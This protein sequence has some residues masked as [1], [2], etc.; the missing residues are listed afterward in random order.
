MT[1][2]EIRPF[3]A[4]DRDWLVDAHSRLYAAEEG[5]D[6]SFGPLVAD[7][8]DKFIADHD[9]QDE[10][11]WIA[12]EGENR[13]GSIFCVRLD[14]KRAK[15]RLF[16]LQPEARGKGL[17]L[18]LLN[19]CMDFARARGYSGMQLWT[20]E[21]HRAACALYQRNGW[22][23]TAQ[24]PVHAFGQDLIEQTYEITF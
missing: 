10:A 8:L 23:V 14:E 21:S 17:G 24:K 13:L 1:T 3:T 5:F 9:S 15:L 12:W 2:I 22:R 6:T 16:L 4:A 20:H 11:G 7:I 19:T 18:R